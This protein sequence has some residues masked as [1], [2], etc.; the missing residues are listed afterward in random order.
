MRLGF[1]WPTPAEL[2]EGLA[3]ISASLRVARS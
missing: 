1:G 3:N 2:A